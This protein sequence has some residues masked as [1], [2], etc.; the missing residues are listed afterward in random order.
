MKV[1]AVHYRI[2]DYPTALIQL[3]DAYNLGFR[4]YPQTHPEGDIPPAPNPLLLKYQKTVAQL[5]AVTTNYEFLKNQL[6]NL[7][8]TIIDLQNKKENV[9]DQITTLKNK[10]QQRRNKEKYQYKSEKQQLLEHK[11]KLE[12]EQIKI[13]IEISDLQGFECNFEIST[14]IREYKL[15]KAKI[16]SELAVLEKK[17]LA[18]NSF[19]DSTKNYNCSE[20]ATLK[21]LLSD[22][23]NI[24]FQIQELSQPQYY[25]NQLQ[26][27]EKEIILALQNIELMMKEASKENI[28]LPSLPASVFY[29]I[30]RY[31]LYQL[32][33]RT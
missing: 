17:I 1:Q 15:D 2:G 8:N 22:Y 30:D 16:E 19:I 24:E 26:Q 7:P 3:K 27:K 23:D 12:L 25:E 32:S 13:E 9:N 31:D 4:Y 5:K 33:Q 14:F 28:C 6:H 20:K 21:K 18:V 11:R 29:T 10:S